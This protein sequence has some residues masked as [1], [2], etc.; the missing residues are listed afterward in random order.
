MDI[1]LILGLIEMHHFTI[2]H[3]DSCARC[4]PRSERTTNGVFWSGDP[5][6]QR[7]RYLP[8]DHRHTG[9][10]EQ[11]RYVLH[12]MCAKHGHIVILRMIGAIILKTS[13]D[14]RYNHGRLVLFM[15]SRS[16]MSEGHRHHGRP[17]RLW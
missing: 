10:N 3:L 17:F 11:P 6:W 9:D 13:A 14:T 12:R 4:P 7:R 5:S 16:A 2:M 15:R 8:A 1:S